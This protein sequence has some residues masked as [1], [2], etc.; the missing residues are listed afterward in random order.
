MQ[1]VFVYGTLRAGEPNDIRHAAA[2]HGLAEPRLIGV[3]A[4]RGKLYDFGNYPGLVLDEAGSPVTG[5]VYEIEDELI[6]VL[7]EIER[8]YPG[9]DGMFVG[10]E[11]TFDVAGERVVC[12]YYPVT[13]SAVQDKPEITGGDWV[14]HR[15]SR[16]TNAEQ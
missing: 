8:A 4:V 12:L 1:N 2:S 11:M 9:I 14:A 7:D 3:T 13:E 10:R 6:A 5:D 16:V 15:R